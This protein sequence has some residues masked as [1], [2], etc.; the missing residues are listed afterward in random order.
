MDQQTFVQYF[1][2]SNGKNIE[3]KIP[4]KS[5]PSETLSRS[6]SAHKFHSKF[7]SI[8]P[9]SYRIL[10]NC[11]RYFASRDSRPQSRSTI[12]NRVKGGMK[13]E[14]WK[15]EP[16]FSN[17]NSWRERE[18]SLLPWVPSVLVVRVSTESTSGRRGSSQLTHRPADVTTLP[19]RSRIHPLSQPSKATLV[20]RDS[21][22]RRC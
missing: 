14:G 17:S 3:L 16:P 20:F 22:S 11:Y 21:S 4:R 19:R 5:V 1:F 12:D 15:E 18:P 8:L 13:V 6:S 2:L 10:L 7:Y 9:F